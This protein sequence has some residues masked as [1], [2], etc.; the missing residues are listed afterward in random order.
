MSMNATE[1]LPE[2]GTPLLHQGHSYTVGVGVVDEWGCKNLPVGTTVWDG[3]QVGGPEWFTKA[4]EGTN[5]WIRRSSSQPQRITHS[6][7]RL[8]SFPRTAEPETLAEFKQRFGQGVM[9]AT[10]E[11]SAAHT[12]VAKRVL[13]QL[14]AL[15]SLVGTTIEWDSTPPVGT[16][17]MHGSPDKREFTIFRFGKDGWVK[18]SGHFATIEDAVVVT[19]VSTPDNQ[20]TEVPGDQEALIADFKAEVWT[21]GQDLKQRYKWCSQYERI[22]GEF[23]IVDPV[24]LPDFS[25]WPVK[26]KAEEGRVNLPVGAVLCVAEGDWGIFRKTGLPNVWARVCGT[27]PL[28]AGTMSLM[29]SGVGP[30]DIP[31]VMPPLMDL[32]PVGTRV[33]NSAGNENVKG[34]DGRWHRH[35]RTFGSEEFTR[36]VAIVGWP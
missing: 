4:E 32:L 1:A 17:A 9:E 12:R 14:G 24:A 35:G 27:R 13:T 3:A 16:V 7:N 23:G 20:I 18:T 30:V 15:P 26:V 25:A 28:C 5:Q 2:V 6:Y 31:H 34:V 33:L 36:G 19:V 11:F 8:R 22:L 10:G 21:M 29:F